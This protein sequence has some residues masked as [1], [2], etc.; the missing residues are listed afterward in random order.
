MTPLPPTPPP[1]NAELDLE[2][3]LTEAYLFGGLSAFGNVNAVN[4][5]TAPAE[6]ATVVVLLLGGDVEADGRLEPDRP[7]FVQPPRRF[8][9]L[10][11]ILELS[12]PR[13]I[14]EIVKHDLQ[15]ASS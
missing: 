2:L 10:S 14:R 5:N 8:V 11:A 15:W 7:L 1:R 9:G 6:A 12:S 13:L 4:V 3:E